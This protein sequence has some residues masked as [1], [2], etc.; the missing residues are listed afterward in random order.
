VH[1]AGFA[2]ERAPRRHLGSIADV[3]RQLFP[4]SK[5]LPDA[6]SGKLVQGYARVIPRHQKLRDEFRQVSAARQMAFDPHRGDLWKACSRAYRK[7]SR[8]RSSRFRPSLWM[9]I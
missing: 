3:R 5:I 2:I 4:T 6:Q 9:P 7:C 1:R 8:V